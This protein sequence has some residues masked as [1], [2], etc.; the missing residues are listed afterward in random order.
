MSPAAPPPT[1]PVHACPACGET[2]REVLHTGLADLAFGVAGGRWTLYRCRGC[3]A[4]YLDPRPADEALGGLYAS[5][6]THDPPKPNL[7]PRGRGARVARALRNGHLD[8][9]LGYELRPSLRLGAVLARLLPGFAALAERPV[10][11]LPAGARVLDLGAGNGL[12]VAEA[13]AWGLRAAGIELD[14]EG[15]AAGRKAG[16][17]LA[18]ETA[19]ERA[20]REPGGYDAVT[21]SHV[22][23]HVPDPVALLRDCAALLRPG[24]TVWIATPNLASAGHQRFGETWLHLDPP[25]HL[26][27]FDA[28]SLK[29]AA[30]AAGLED[31]RVLHPVPDAG[32]VFAASAAIG[33]GEVAGLTPP[34][35]PVA[36]QLAAIAANLRAQLRPRLAEELVVVAR[37]A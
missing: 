27:L 2:A 10:R 20:A 23:E 31:T 33:R 19:A 12:F 14:E 4:A 8:R 28:P 13:C 35:P 36:V 29:A 1:V 34:P 9:A 21:L 3:G 30:A 5:Y 11:G 6:Y 37:S 22:I 7:E 17:D 15:V 18:V 16:L 24:G 26:V 25:R 32:Q